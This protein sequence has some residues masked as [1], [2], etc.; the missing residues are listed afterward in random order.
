M[1]EII[2]ADLA[3]SEFKRDPE[4]ILGPLRTNHPVARIALPNGG[5]AWLITRWEDVNTIFKDTCFRKDVRSV[6]SA[7]EI[8][9]TFSP[10]EVEDLMLRHLAKTDPPE[11]TRLRACFAPLFAPHRVEGW[12]EDVQAIVNDTIAQLPRSGSVDLVSSFASRIPSLAVCRLLVRSSHYQPLLVAY[13]NRITARDIDAPV[14]DDVRESLEDLLLLV[15][16]LI[17]EIRAHPEEGLLG[18]WLSTENS[19][20]TLTTEEIL[21]MVSVVIRA[22]IAATSGLLANGTLL[23]LQHP[24]QMDLLRKEPELIDSAIEE[25]VRC[26]PPSA[27]VTPRW[28]HEDLKMHGQ[29]LQ[30][31]DMVL[32]AVTAANHDPAAFPHPERFDIR[33]RDNH[34]F[35]FGKG[36]HYC[37]GAS[38]ARL[39]ARTAFSALLNGFPRMRLGCSL[40]QVPWLP[41]MKISIPQSLP[42]ELDRHVACSL[43]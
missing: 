12:R 21:P 32:I 20:G 16:E 42:V 37:L 13:A 7:E 25:M 5:T 29:T 27:F 11:H 31:G 1:A 24:D 3:S 38:L 43:T 35:G 41:G 10:L 28:V 19:G 9:R 30:R 18:D 8:A 39:E 14:T 22:G 40:E 33:R 17:R 2:E 26:R 36:I 6:L 15:Q 34:H 23:L 4:R